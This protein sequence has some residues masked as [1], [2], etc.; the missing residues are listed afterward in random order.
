VPRPAA[1]LWDRIDEAMI[2]D[3]RRLRRALRS[4]QDERSRPRRP[5]H[6]PSWTI[7]RVEDA[8]RAS[9]SR[10]DARAEALPKPEFPEELP[11]VQRRDEIAAAIA[12]NQVVV[13]CGE[14]GS[15]KTT[16]LPK[17]CLSLG[18]GVSG[19]IGHTQPRRI[20]ARSVAGR[21]ASE[22]GTSLGHAVGYKVR[23]TDKTSPQS[24]I[25]VMTDGILLAETQTDPLLEKYDTLIIDEAHERSLNIDFL[26]GYLR[27]LLPKRPD[28]KL[29]ITS[30]T[31]DP[32][33]FAAHFGTPGMPAPIIEV[34]GRTY[35]VEVRYRPPAPTSPEGEPDEA[36]EI[37]YVQAILDAVDELSGMPR[38]AAEDAPPGSAVP[39]QRGRGKLDGDV[40]IFLPGEREI[41]E[42]AEALRKH[43]PMGVEILP[44]YARLSAGEQQRVFETR[45]GGRRIVLA[46]NVAETSLTVPGIKY[47][48]DPGLARISRYSARTKVQRLPIEPI[49]RASADQRKGRCGR[50]SSGVCVRLYSEEDYLAR[51]QFTEPE[52]LR[53]NLASVILQMKALRLGEVVDF[54]FVERPDSR[55][56]RDGY[57]TL[58]ELGAVDDR[59]SLTP[60]GSELAHLPIDPRIARM[61][62]AGAQEHCLEEVL[63][64]AAALSIQD[65]RERPM[66]K[67]DAADAAHKRFAGMQQE[68]DESDFLTYLHIWRFYKEQSEHLSH[69]KLRKACQQNFLSPSRMREWDEVHRQVHAIIAE[70]ALPGGK[71]YVFNTRAATGDAVHRA[72]LTGLLSNVGLKGDGHE[73]A[74]ARGIKFSIFPGS[75][76]FKKNPKWVMAAEIVQTTKMYARTVARAQPEW[77]ERAAA[78]LVKKTYAEPVWDAPRAR[79]NAFEKVLLFGL[80]VVPR[81]A[82]HFGPINPVLARE[83]FITHALVNGEWNTRLP[84][85]EHNR[86]LL[87]D[88][89]EQESRARRRNLLAPPEKRAAFFDQ[90]IPPGVFSGDTFE[91]WRKQAE[92]EN[93]KLLFM[94]LKDALA[95]DAVADE[96]AEAFPDSI[97]LGGRASE[98]NVLSVRTKYHFEPGHADDGVTA[99]I[100]LGAMN[101]VDPLRAE[102]LVPGLLREKLTALIRALPKSLRTAFVPAPQFAERAADVMEARLKASDAAPP[103][104]RSLAEALESLTGLHVPIESWRDATLDPHLS[105][106][107]AVVDPQGKRLA[108]GRQLDRVRRAV[109]AQ[110]RA[111]LAKAP[112]PL[113]NR[114]R[115][116]EWDF[117]DLPVQTDV[118]SGGLHMVGFPAIVEPDDRRGLYVH[119]RLLD[120]RDA[121]RAAMHAGVR[122]LFL[123]QVHKE[124]EFLLRT[125]PGVQ[126]LA[127][128]YAPLG[129]TDML[130]HELATFIADRAFLGD[131]AEIRSEAEFR[132]RLDPGWCRLSDVAHR[133]AQ[134]LEAIL[135]EYQPLAADLLTDAEHPV[136]WA[137]SLIDMREQLRHL[138]FPGF[139]SSVPSAWL[140]HYPR[141]LAAMRARLGKLAT[142]GPARDL[143]HLGEVTPLWRAYQVRDASNTENDVRDPALEQ[144]RWMS[145]ELRVSLFAQEL[146][147][148]I[149]V[150]AKRLREYWAKSIGPALPE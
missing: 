44:L 87:R 26:L 67:A 130:R 50:V 148:S 110:L 99:L 12:A 132:R 72:L 35:P 107:F 108:S 57:D 122:R 150:S 83:M 62:I 10:R 56:I 129:K 49:S 104:L 60:I 73:Y 76:L 18:R 143:K 46:T 22:L 102:W 90:R 147:T 24:F 145:E 21:I 14:T 41:R 58:H 65:P 36:G 106:N 55:L 8:L 28:L 13:L 149:P 1:T 68:G 11:V 42:T 52:I 4:A 17:I 139:L 47:V 84:F 75:A 103:L 40:L 136:A 53:T 80:E 25:K 142:T 86:R 30:A 38:R 119:M 118:K 94:A 96:S 7:A 32:E 39:L 115:V 97:P 89:Q 6:Q 74:G 81:R 111:A 131:G 9:V 5:G 120:T 78:H 137:E 37:D 66:D 33:R 140:G 105:M 123:V 54:P 59:G 141:F 91:H 43:H 45:Q 3:R 79:V 61:V 95:D 48:V 64:I 117:G 121:S 27:Q 34:S 31:I 93:P 69:N 77:I 114:E 88:V 82:V 71:K 116:T 92:R 134:D 100:P 70:R 51:P 144:F 112:H 19:M 85:A 135:R 98:G 113:Y 124:I 101:R 16:Q 63:V 127:L 23:F 2:A 15:G 29:I 146:R 109:R 138:V 125:L 20:A 133:A 126:R 128:L